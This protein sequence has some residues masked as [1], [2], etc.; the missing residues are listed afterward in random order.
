[1][2]QSTSLRNLPDIPQNQLSRLQQR[3][4]SSED[5]YAQE[6]R[7]A[8]GSLQTTPP[9]PTNS[10][11]RKAVA[12]AEFAGAEEPNET[13][14]TRDVPRLHL[15][16]DDDLVQN[17][18]SRAL[19]GLRTPDTTPQIELPIR[20][21]M[22]NGHASAIA[23][24]QSFSRASSG[25]F[26]RIEEQDEDSYSEP[27]QEH[28]GLQYHAFDD[29]PKKKEQNRLSHAAN[30]SVASSSSGGDPSHPQ[31]GVPKAVVNLQRQSLGGEL[32]GRTLSPLSADGS[33]TSPS[34]YPRDLSN[35]RRSPA[36][37]PSS[38][39]D[40]LNDVPYSQ[41]VAPAGQLQHQSLRNVVGRAASLLDMKKTL[42]MY[43]LNVKKTTDA[44]VQYE[45][46]IYMISC[47][48]DPELP[49]DID[50]DQLVKEAKDIL[51]DLAGRS[52]PFA[53]Y[54][55]ADGLA[56]GLF[57]KGKPDLTRS[58][59]LFQAASKHQHA[60]AGYRTALCYEFG[61]GTTKSYPKAVQYYRAA[62]SKNHPGAATR[63]GMAC[64]R[65]DMGLIGKDKYR[66]GIRWLKRAQ[67][68][69]DF[70]YNAAPFE[71]GLLHLQGFGADIFKDEQYAAQL[72]TQAAELGNV[73]ANF[74]MGEAY[75]NGSYGCPKD[76]ALS[77]HFYN[78]AATRG[79]AESMMALCAWYMVGAE[80]VL[81]KDERE[82]YE[83]AKK[84]AETG[85]NIPL[86]IVKDT[87]LTQ[88][89]YR[90][91]KSRICGR[92]LHRNGHRLPPRPFRSKHVVRP[93]R[94][95]RQ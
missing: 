35:S 56:S 63:L 36:S 5:I 24:E 46:A 59:H 85:R 48:Q 13:N 33:E 42:E 32:R 19:S 69:A 39:I 22:A 29:A 71:L 10:I 60:E 77:V 17:G 82:A 53:Q 25:S 34:G 70:Q 54:Y 23:D 72:F 21:R 95:P 66:E 16:D 2:A 37:R 65:S 49:P 44:A 6:R 45:F 86:Y 90:L 87:W 57:N 75:E 38:Y 67:E 26:P 55:L 15:V 8:G 91:P 43:R 83:W 18:G 27:V 52:Y 94:R 20:S 80:P 31:L 58:F 73:E 64:L 7:D 89:C 4:D 68:S 30:R 40:L 62:A 1:M 61:W 79:H 88:Q 28:E 93:C 12:N 81:E 78:G 3:E 47:S 14:T 41:Q 51:T 76:A 9:R 74:I 11:K 92:L 50:R 84:A